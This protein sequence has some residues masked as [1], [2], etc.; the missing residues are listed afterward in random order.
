MNPKLKTKLGWS[1]L[2]I[3][4]FIPTLLLFLL[5]P[6][7]HYFFSYPVFTQKLGQIF[8]L[9]AIMMFAI[10]FILSTRIKFIEDL[11]GGLDKVYV[12]H[13]ILGGTALIL[14]LFHPIFL[15]LKFIP[16]DVTQAAEYLLP[17]AYWSVNFGIIAI[18][19]LI[20]LIYITVYTRIRYHN[21]KI[22]HKFLGLVFIFAVLHMFMVRDDAARDFIFSGYYTFA[23]IVSVI[24]L[25][26]FSYT[27]FL[28]KRILQEAV[29]IIEEIEKKNSVY[30]I[31]F[32]PE[33]KPLKYKSGQFIYVRFYNKRLSKEQ[34]PF[35]IASKSNDTRI[36][37]VVK[38][39]GDF[40]SGLHTLKEGDKVLIEGPY[41]RFN[42]KWEDDANQIWI[43]GGIG[44]TPFLG[45]AE[46]LPQD[47]KSKIDLYY[48]VSH[49]EDFIG[50]KTLKSIE[51]N[52]PNFRVFP[53]ITKEKGR[54]NLNDIQ[55]NSGDLK[56]KEFYMC[57][58]EALKDS[59]K[60]QLVKEG[61]KDKIYEEVFNFR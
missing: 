46:N 35:S 54:L 60:N 8:A 11:F 29:Y 25:S 23:T 6:K 26:G 40:T 31:T 27:L 39:L 14:I 38:N 17:S 18:L 15:V 22:S 2:I 53:W 44:I 50:L 57:G 19:G 34:H 56:S 5:G 52:N 42:H 16:T 58:P 49:E 21:W 33:R 30:E 20:G 7:T 55:E 41:G 32:V 59:I 36:K 37:I 4:S 13:S 12:V 43:A 1:I 51:E 9:T 47:M 28:K 45:M 61:I 10:T 48:T 24:G 3:I